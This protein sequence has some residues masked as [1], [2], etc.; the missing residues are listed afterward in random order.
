MISN[1][2]FGTNLIDKNTVRIAIFSE[3]EKNINHPFLLHINT[4]RIE[5][6]A[7]KKQTFLNGVFMFDCFFEEG[8][9]LGNDYNISLYPFGIYPLNVNGATDF[10]DFDKNYFYNGDDLGFTYTKKATTFK[11]W[12]PL[13]SRCVVLLKKGNEKFQ[14]YVM[15]R[16]EKGVYSLTLNGDFDGYKYRYQV[17]NSGTSIITTDPYGKASS[18][19]GRDSVVVDFNKTKIDLYEKGLPTYKNNTDAIIYELHV[20]DFTIDNNTNIVNKGKYLGLTETKRTTK[21]GHM[22]GIDHIEFMGMTHVQLLPIYDYC[23]VDELNTDKSYN[24]GYDPQQYFCPEGGFSSDPNDPYSRI[25]ELKKAIAAFHKKK[26]KVNMDVVFNHVYDVLR[27]PLEII[28]PNY[29]FRKNKNGVLCT[30]S[31]CGNDVASERLMTRKLIVDCCKY[32]VKEYGIDGF[33]FDLMGLTDITTMNL[34]AEEIR[35]IKKDAMIYGEGWNMDT[36][37]AVDERAAI[38]NSFQMPE[39]GFFND[40]YRDI[41]RGPNGEDK[42]SLPGYFA[43]NTDFREGFKYSLLSTSVKYVY[44]PRFIGPNQSINYCECHD[45]FTLFDKIAKSI[46]DEKDVKRIMK[47]VFSI[48]EAILLSY[49]VPFFHAG[50]EIGLTKKF[51]DNTYNKGDEYNKFRYDIL[52]QR[53]EYVLYLKTMIELRK[54][55]KINDLQDSIEIGKNH[56]FHDLPNGAISVSVN[57]PND[58]NVSY[59]LIFNPTNQTIVHDLGDYHYLIAG[60]IGYIKNSDIHVQ[61]IMIQPYSVSV[62]KKEG[63]GK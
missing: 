51:V 7:I 23:T 25:I 2:Y 56:F 46:G 52:D 59:L 13:A 41:L 3:V 37:L 14:S 42:L 17:T 22:A 35:S 49:G 38:I 16:E 4:D 26:I 62:Y 24:W 53:Y 39:I 31:G 19:N 36:N 28:V 10:E 29:Y 58:K 18:A 33:R 21:K 60:K 57:S 61:T 47:I 27:S 11:V 1:T 30:G 20:R 5:K 6:L 54:N 8:F 45:N 9:E 55:L 15:T 34:V 40:V 63:I 44:D 12:A 48:N 50:Q 32:W 43:G